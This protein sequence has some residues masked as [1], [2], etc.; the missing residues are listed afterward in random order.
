MSRRPNGACSVALT[1]ADSHFWPNVDKSGECWMW[2]GSKTPRGYGR[3]TVRQQGSEY[4]HRF[5][6]RL[7]GGALG[8]GVE[9]C[10][11]CDNPSCVRPDHLFAGTHS[12]NM[13]D[14]S[15]KGRTRNTFAATSHCK[16][17]H[18]WTDENTYIQSNGRRG[19]RPCTRELQRQ[20]ALRNPDKVKASW[21]ASN[22]KRARKN[23]A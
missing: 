21:Q 23:V 14:A 8:T 10:H 7:H 3:L 16:N 19:C 4:A 20:W 5:S 22:A 17:G 15:R 11:S 9:C 6:F 2:T 13:R 12:D 1:N 18:P